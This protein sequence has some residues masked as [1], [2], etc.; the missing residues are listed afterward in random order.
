MIFHENRLPADDSHEISCLIC[1]FWKS[2]Q[3]WNCRLLQIIGCAL[4]VKT[5]PDAIYWLGPPRINVKLWLTVSRILFSLIHHII[6]IWF[7]LSLWW[8]IAWFRESKEEGI[9]QESIQSSNTSDPG[10]HGKVINSQLDITNEEREPRGQPF[11]SR[12]PRGINLFYFFNRRAQ[13]H[14]NNKTEK[15]VN[16]PQKKHDLGSLHAN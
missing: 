5:S 14:N 3:I 16:G 13:K 8:C 4:W 9:Y 2:N 11:P 10:Y 7:D 6:L 1:Y 15:N 12:W